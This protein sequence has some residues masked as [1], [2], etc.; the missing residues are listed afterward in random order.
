MDEES[1]SLNY[2]KAASYRDKIV[3]L[4]QIQS[5]QK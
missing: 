1:K 2:E 5:Q 4:T 3:A